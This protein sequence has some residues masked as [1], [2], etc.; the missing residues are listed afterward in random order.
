M[1]LKDY[2][3]RNNKTASKIYYS[4]LTPKEQNIQFNIPSVSTLIAIQK[5][6]IAN[7]G[8]I[9]STTKSFL[10]SVNNNLSQGI[11]FN[12]ET[13]SVDSIIRKIEENASQ[14]Y[15]N[16]K[17]STKNLDSTTII[18]NYQSIINEWNN[19][20]HIIKSSVNLDGLPGSSLKPHLLK[21]EAKKIAAENALR[22]NNIPTQIT[23]DLLKGLKYIGNMLKGLYLEAVGQNMIEKNPQQI[24]YVSIPLGQILNVKGKQLSHD[25]LAMTMDMSKANLDEKIKYRVGKEG[26]ELSA[27]TW[28]EFLKAIENSVQQRQSI[29][30]LN[31]N[32]LDDLATT[33]QAKAAINNIRIKNTK[34]S[35]EELLKQINQQSYLDVHIWSLYKL[36]QFSDAFYKTNPDYNYLSDFIIS[37]NLAK[38]LSNKSKIYLLRNGFYDTRS[39]IMKLLTQGEYVHSLGK[40][41]IKNGIGPIVIS[42]SNI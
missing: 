25:L 15:L 33:I 10:D 2:L 18:N 7:M 34:T 4:K 31:D 37:K 5:K 16:E 1:L 35:M 29:Y 28:E 39:L 32:I 12:E 27:S 23:P 13:F 8:P 36:N 11:A 17:F 30:L 22:Q 42:G 41:H 40:T 24:Q 20:L 9:D 3:L 26:Q 21:L 14:F 6:S 19:L 38:I